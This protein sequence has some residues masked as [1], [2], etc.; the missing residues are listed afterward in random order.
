MEQL[1]TSLTHAVESAPLIALSAAMLWGILSILL[2]PCHLASIPMIVG[3]IDDQGETAPLRALFISLLF[4]SGILVTIALIGALTAAAG[5]MMGDIGSYG[6]YLVAIIFFV[7]GL[8]LLG[9]IPLGWSKPDQTTRRRKG[10]I[11]AFLLGLIFGIA[12]G[13]CSFAFMAPL[14]GITFKLGS[15]QPVYAGSLLIMYGLG[16]CGVIALAGVCTGQVQRYKEWNERSHG[17]LRLKKIC[18]TLVL[19]GGLYMLYT[20]P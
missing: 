20:A 8:N 2:S 19:L 18:G 15:E 4:A 16:H 11:G 1:F 17:A 3:Y 13:P 9:V 10:F 5:R 14:L 12:L 7:V 6:N